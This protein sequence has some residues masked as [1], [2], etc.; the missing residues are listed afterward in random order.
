MA[1]ITGE[2][3]I[4]GLFPNGNEVF[5]S[6]E[7]VY[8]LFLIFVIFCCHIVLMNVFT[9]LAVGDVATVMRIVLVLR[10][11]LTSFDPR[12]K[13][14]QDVIVNEDHGQKLGPPRRF[15]NGNEGFKNPARRGRRRHEE[16]GPG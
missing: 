1:I 9:G 13:P 3:N 4:D 16:T 14:L 11:Q 12:L 2:F 10:P 7:I 8:I 6:N 5:G 15:K